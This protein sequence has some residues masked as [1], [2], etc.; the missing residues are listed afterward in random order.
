MILACFSAAAATVGVSD[1]SDTAMI[2][3]NSRPDDNRLDNVTAIID[4]NTRPDDNRLDTAAIDVNTR[5][6]DNRLSTL[7]KDHIGDSC[8]TYD[9]VRGYPDLNGEITHL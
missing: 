8:D 7:Q 1:A 3:T 4:Y 9:V 2:D 6:D 5:P